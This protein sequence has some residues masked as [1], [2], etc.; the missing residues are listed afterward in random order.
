MITAVHQGDHR[1]KIYKDGCDLGTIAVRENR[2][3]SEHLYLEMDLDSYD[4]MD[5]EQLFSALYIQL[6]RPMQVMTYSDKQ[7]ICAFLRAGGFECRRRCL[8][9][10]A[11]AG[12]LL[13]PASVST[14][15]T[16]VTSDMPEYEE[17]CRILYEYYAAT[18]AAINPL[19]ADYPA[20][21][22][23]LPEKVVFLKE[24]NAITHLA[25][26]EE[27]EIAYLASR[28]CSSIGPFLDSLVALHLKQWQKVSFECDDC[29]PAAMALRAMF[30]NREDISY[31]TYVY[32]HPGSIP[33]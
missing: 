5:A 7:D 9:V 18:H 8:E 24:E 3:H 6:C 15:L 33:G 12:D 28:N 30:H 29:D 27:E 31:D 26:V 4:P 14:V 32:N 1:Y 11:G 21:C 10:E 22:K 19:T 16:E 2:F 20:F 17:C 25:F 13:R 23:V